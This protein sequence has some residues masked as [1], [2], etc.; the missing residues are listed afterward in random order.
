MKD[1]NMNFLFAGTM[2]GLSWANLAGSSSDSKHRTTQLGICVYVPG[3]GGA[4]RVLPGHSPPGPYLPRAA[5]G[6]GVFA[7]RVCY[8]CYSLAEPPSIDVCLFVSARTGDW[9]CWCWLVSF[10]SQKERNE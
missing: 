8:C 4:C 3:S 5:D 7:A 1:A 10:H 6:C 9:Y 2:L